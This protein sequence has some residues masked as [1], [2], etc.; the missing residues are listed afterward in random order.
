MSDEEVKKL[1][2]NAERKV[3]LWTA[4]VVILSLLVGTGGVIASS[5]S[6]QGSSQHAVLNTR[7]ESEERILTLTTEKVN[8]IEK[9]LA[10][11]VANQEMVLKIIDRLESRR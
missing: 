7:L 4:I 5:L 1:I 10:K 11:V 6:A 3:P 8:T 9:T 2:K